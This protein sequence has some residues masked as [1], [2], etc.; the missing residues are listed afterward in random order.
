MVLLLVPLLLG[1]GLGAAAF[2]GICGDGQLESGEQCDAGA[3]NGTEA[4]CCT[5]TCTLVQP[6][7]PCEPDGDRCIDHMCLPDGDC[8]FPETVT[9]DDGNACT[10][11]H[12]DPAARCIYQDRVCQDDDVCTQDRCDEDAGCEFPAEPAWNCQAARRSRLRIATNSAAQTARIS[13][14]WVGGPVAPADLGD[15]TTTTSYAACVYDDQGVVL[16][17]SAPAGAVC[18]GGHPCWTVEPGRRVHYR[19]GRRLSEGDVTRLMASVGPA[20]RRAA[21]VDLDAGG[22][23][24][25]TPDRPAG[26]SPLVS[27]QVTT[28]DGACF[29][30]TFGP[31]EI[32]P[33]D[34]TRF[35]ARY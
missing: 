1:P 3:A 28:S 33:N 13:L 19:N 15:P 21:R 16:R 32:G 18:T 11:E 25:F 20:P 35:E 14:E 6:G 2:A 31:G 27:A 5:A 24:L 9:C 7:T 26:L 23:G 8:G 4:V 34:G 17:L 29:G 30:A 10:L 22:S 12:C